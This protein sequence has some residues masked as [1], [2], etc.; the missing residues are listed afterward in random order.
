VSCP[1]TRR[2]RAARAGAILVLSAA[3]GSAVGCAIRAEMRPDLSR[4]YRSSAKPRY[5]VILIPGVFGSRLRDA[6]TG[7]VV[8]GRAASF[9][10]RL[11]RPWDADMDLLDL[12]LDAD[13]PLDNRDRLEPAGVFDEVAGHEYYAR[14]LNTLRDVGGYRPGDIHHPRAG[15]NL[16]AFDYD[17]RRDAAETA[18]LLSDAI[19]RILAARG[20]PD[21]QVDLV[22]HSLGGLVARYYVLYGGED[23]LGS[24]APAPSYSGAR[25]VHTVVYLG[26]P[27]AG[28]LDAFRS[29]VEGT[30]I[31]RWLPA[32]AVFTMPAAYELLP[33]PGE[34]I[35][36]DSSGEPLHADIF[37]VATWE[38]FGWSALDP[39]RLAELRSRLMKEHGEREGEKRFT[40]EKDRLRRFA[41]WALGRARRFIGALEAGD[42]RK[43]PVRYVAF[44]GDCRPT[45]A[46]AVV[47][48]DGSRHTTHFDPKTLPKELRT[49]RVDLLMLEPGD[50][51]VTR[52]SLLGAHAGGA[53]GDGSFRLSSAMFLCE[54]H[55]HLTENIAFQDNLLHMLLEGGP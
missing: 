17:W 29:L 21:G 55:R 3:L 24:D 50:G 2:R 32:Q 19:E 34:E 28:T 22:G 44:G 5:P 43:D 20:E 9:F 7:R 48:F 37:D 13:N 26:A 12:P 11:Y 38:K 18:R 35:I 42:A 15:E 30:R 10:M 8:W 25:H 41:G 47:L 39:E 52:A 33:H 27:N 23:V 6:G 16:F 36:V 51:S 49:P 14:V 45:P 31:G 4:V 1:E 53:P 46:R 40:E 54:S